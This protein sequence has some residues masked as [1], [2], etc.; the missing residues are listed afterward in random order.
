MEAP[1]DH[2][3]RPSAL[4]PEAFAE[5]AQAI[6]RE[7]GT[8]HRRPARARP[9][10]ADRAARQ[11]P[12]PARGRARAWARR[13]SC[14]R[15]PTSSTARSTA[16]S[17]RPDLMPADITGTNILIEEGGQRVFRFQPGPDLRQP[18]PRRRDQPGDAQDPVEPARGDA[19]A[20]GHRRP[21]ALPARSAVLRPRHAEPARDGGH[22]SPARGAARPV[23]VQ[24]HGALPVRGG[25][26]R[27]HG[28]H[29]RRR[30]P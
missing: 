13:C 26:R 16:S 2:R 23:P 7:V 8:G 24:G 22:L 19:G 25:P 6:E 20:P 21:P 30:E 17:S 10:D 3:P 14:A 18:R 9:A 11:Q 5:R 4:A 29:D 1:T 15:S 12:R 28:S 27:D